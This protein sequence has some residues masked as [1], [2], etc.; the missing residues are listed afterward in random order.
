[1]FEST[2]LHSLVLLQPCHLCRKLPHQHVKDTI[3]QHMLDMHPFKVFTTGWF[4]ST[5]LLLELDHVLA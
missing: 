3:L 2:F 4:I 5:L 1:M